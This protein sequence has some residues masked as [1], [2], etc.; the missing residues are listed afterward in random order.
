MN[1]STKGLVAAGAAATLLLGGAGTLAYWNATDGIDG[2]SIDSGSLAL[3]NE[4]GTWEL[5]GVSVL[6]PTTV[7]LVPGDELEFVGT[8]EIDAT[9]D[10]LEATVSVTG[11]AE[12]GTLADDVTTTTAFTLAGTALTGTD[13]IDET[14]DGETLG[15]TITIDFPFGTTADNL[16]QSSTLD[17]SAIEVV[18]T[19]TDASAPVV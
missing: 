2:G 3:L 7:V 11:G 17:L 8:Y 19:Q 16:S 10:N 9:G 4:A 18:L 1:K 13:T 5:N 12:S 15:V 14:N 6:D